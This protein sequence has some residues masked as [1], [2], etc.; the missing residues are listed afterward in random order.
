MQNIMREINNLLD[1][2]PCIHYLDVIHT[3][4]TNHSAILQLVLHTLVIHTSLLTPDKSQ[5][6]PVLHINH[7]GLL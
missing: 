6:D 7:E 4:K 5:Q 1:I 2:L 3:V